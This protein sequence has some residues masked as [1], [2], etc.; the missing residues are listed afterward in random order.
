MEIKF[1]DDNFTQYMVLDLISLRGLRLHF[2][3]SQSFNSSPTIVQSPAT[4]E[5]RTDRQSRRTK[6]KYFGHFEN[7]SR[8]SA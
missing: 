8:E 5:K 6:K 7:K 2:I 1:N 3:A 4:L